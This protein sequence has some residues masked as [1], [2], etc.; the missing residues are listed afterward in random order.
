MPRHWS[1]IRLER[2]PTIH[3]G[4]RHPHAGIA[5]KLVFREHDER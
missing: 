1:V 5:E 2:I 3:I 4:V